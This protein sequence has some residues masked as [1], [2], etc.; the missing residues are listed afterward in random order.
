MIN[1]DNSN[2]MTIWILSTWFKK[3]TT[4]FLQVNT[5][6]LLVHLE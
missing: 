2:K 1:N 4:G 3:Q 6:L 5:W